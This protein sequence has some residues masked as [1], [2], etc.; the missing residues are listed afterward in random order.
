MPTLF[1]DIEKVLITKDELQTRIAALAAEM[2]AIYDDDDLPMLV[3]ILKGAFMFLADLTRHLDFRHEIDFM[4]ISSYG[5]GTTSGSVRILLDLASDIT[6]RNIII[7][8]DIVDTG[9]TLTYILK[10]FTARGPA[11]VRVATLLSKPSR[12]EVDVAVD[13]VGFEVPD[14]FVMGY[15]LDYAQQ[16]RTITRPNCCTTCTARPTAA[17]IT[18]SSRRAWPR[19][20]SNTSARCNRIRR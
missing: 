16:Y 20:T 6:G 3:C 7:V 12:R 5:S 19:N 9:N 1:D 2:N 8:E 13:F 4:E 11:S 15:G 18:C 10:N 14:E 17:I